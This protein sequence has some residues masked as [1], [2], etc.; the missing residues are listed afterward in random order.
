MPRSFLPA[1]I[2]A[3]IAKPL[4][5]LYNVAG[6]FTTSVD[7]QVMVRV[8]LAGVFAFACANLA[9]TLQRRFGGST[10][11]WF[12][13]WT[14]AQF[15]IPYYAGRTLPNFMALP[16][17][18]LG[19]SFILL[20]EE[21]WGVLFITATATVLRLEIAAFVVPTALQLV[22]TKK[23]T[24]R[25]ALLA[26]AIGGFGSLLFAA[27][28]DYWLWA[29]TL[30]HDQLPGFTAKHTLWPEFSSMLYN[31]VDGK[32]SDWGVMPRH[33][34]AV[35]L[36]KSLAGALPLALF[37]LLWAAVQKITGK[38]RGIFGNSNQART[39][40]EVAKTLLPGAVCLI[41]ALSTVE[42][43]EWRFIVYSY[44]VIN[45]IAASTSAA[46]WVRWLTQ[47]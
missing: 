9:Y 25:N 6:I 11:A 41:I 34:Y 42:H 23:M 16:W 20:Q 10:A 32:A 29:P 31:I 38:T 24:L 37:G 47:I 22:I 18:L 5:A 27:P 36:G 17:F 30:P 28:L 4:L 13:I 8:M 12:T 3:L 14:L 43:K 35:A 40:S 26:G 46:L 7:V 15:H 33:F 45:I 19:I 44:P 2:T 21:F 39:V 1:V